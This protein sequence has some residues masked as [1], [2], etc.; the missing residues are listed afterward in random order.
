MSS[1]S[2]F[3]W[4]VNS[5]SLSFFSVKTLAALPYRHSLELG[6]A[7]VIILTFDKVLSASVLL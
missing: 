4:Y 6:C 2:R 1:S 3:L 7:V 5:V